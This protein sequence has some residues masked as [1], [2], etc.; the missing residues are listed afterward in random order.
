MF[1]LPTL[2]AKDRR[3]F[4]KFVK[5]L[6]KSGYVRFEKSIYMKMTLNSSQTDKII[7]DAKKNLPPDGLI[8]ALTIT[9]KEFNGIDFLLGE[10]TTDVVTSP[11]RVVDL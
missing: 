5:Y 8:A 6:E 10:V 9:E 11:D 3:N 1:D 2:T 7:A 4:Q